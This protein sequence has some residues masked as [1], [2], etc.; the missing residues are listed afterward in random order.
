MQPS[1]L[2][3]LPLDL[4]SR[5]ALEARAG[6]ALMGTCRRLRVAVT[7][8]RWRPPRMDQPWARALPAATLC[9]RLTQLRSVDCA[10]CGGI[11]NI[12]V[13]SS[14][15][16]LVRLDC[17]NCC[18]IKDLTPLSGM[19]HLNYLDASRTNISDLFPLASLPALRHLNLSTNL[20]LVNV[21]PLVALSELQHLDISCCSDLADTAPLARLHG[22]RVLNVSN[23]PMVDLTHLATLT[24]LLELCCGSNDHIVDLAPLAG[25]TGLQK[26]NL[27]W[28]RQLVDVGPLESLT[29]LQ[30][31]VIERTKVVDL[32]PLGIDRHRAY[33]GL[34]CKALRHIRI[35]CTKVQDVGPLASLPDL[36]CIRCR[37]CNELVVA[38]YQI[39]RTGLSIDRSP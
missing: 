31:L 30:T 22:L 17:S 20:Q 8:L 2:L 21:A 12:D 4:L 10:G 36:E 24:G 11:E 5:V 33:M 14:L 1:D 39:W 3:A 26:L 18:R 38:D 19:M 37:S 28:N 6:A 34:G 16:G 32:T 13:L 9:L 7:K 25:L 15:P 27:G 35:C 29:R 23:V